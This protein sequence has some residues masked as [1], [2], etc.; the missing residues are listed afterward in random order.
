MEGK[1]CIRD[2]LGNVTMP[3]QFRLK[4][5][6]DKVKDEFDLCMIDCGPSVSPVSYTHLD[7]YKR[8]LSRE[9]TE[10]DKIVP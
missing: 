9:E 5:Q 10:G 7:V 4:K 2:R 6:L 8:Q 3:Q 1:M